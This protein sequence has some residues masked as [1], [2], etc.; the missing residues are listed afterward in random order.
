MIADRGWAFPLSRTAKK[1]HFYLDGKS[2]CGKWVLTDG[3]K[4][5]DDTHYSQHNCVACMKARDKLDR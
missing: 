5:Y 2:L 3:V 4:L 1:A